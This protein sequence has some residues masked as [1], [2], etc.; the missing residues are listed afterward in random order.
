MVMSGHM[1]C[2]S[3]VTSKQIGDYGNEVTQILIDPQG[4]DTSA[5]PRGMVA[6]LY[7]SEDG[8]NVQVEYY[9]TITNTWRPN[10][11]FTVSYGAAEMPDYTTI[12]EGYLVVQEHDSGLYRV[13]ENSYVRF[14]GG[15]LRYADATEGKA[16][17]RFGY[18]FNADLALE[19]TDWKWNYG[20]AGSGL[21]NE[22]EG[23]NVSADSRTNLVITDVPYSYFDKSIEVQLTFTL[24]VDG[25]K[26]TAIDRIRERSVLGVA[27]GIL[28]SPNESAEAK[29]YAQS[30]VDALTAG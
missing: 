17:L 22:R 8:E 13:I 16:N 20:V 3:V 9:S 7:F 15:A 12:P 25:V 10:S 29:A 5:T 24:T 4:L 1:T 14:L 6:M 23:E 18:L 11:E 28:A 26:Y 19:T 30:I 21:T 27:E 2:D